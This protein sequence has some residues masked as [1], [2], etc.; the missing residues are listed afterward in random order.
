MSTCPYVVQREKDLFGDASR[1]ILRIIS[2]SHPSRKGSRQK[3][4]TGSGY[5]IS[6]LYGKIY[7]SS[8]TKDIPFGSREDPFFWWCD[9]M[10]K[11]ES[12]PNGGRENSEIRSKSHRSDLPPY[13]RRS[14]LLDHPSSPGGAHSGD[15]H[16]QQVRAHYEISKRIDHPLPSCESSGRHIQVS[17][18]GV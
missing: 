4:I 1:R 14:L 11:V 12:G 6:P 16:I 13:I 2:N 7:P 5:R 9:G 17:R 8:K 3:I 18:G 10:R 15:I